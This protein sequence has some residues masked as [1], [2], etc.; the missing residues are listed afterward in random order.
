MVSG[1]WDDATCTT[2]GYGYI[3]EGETWF[4]SKQNTFSSCLCSTKEFAILHRKL[5]RHTHHRQ[6]MPMGLKGKMLLFNI[7]AKEAER[8]RLGEQRQL[9]VPLLS[10]GLFTSVK[11][12]RF[13]KTRPKFN[14]VKAQRLKAG[15]AT[16]KCR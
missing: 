4:L 2:S 3:C 13:S 15:P 14:E 9:K 10:S 11:S 8:S 16:T 12:S 1:G 5:R 7:H 6:T